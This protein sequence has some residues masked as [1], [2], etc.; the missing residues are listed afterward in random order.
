MTSTIRVVLNGNQTS[1][2]YTLI[3]VEPPWTP[4]FPCQPP[5]TAR[6]QMVA[7]LDRGE[8]MHGSLAEDFYV[9]LDQPQDPS[10]FIL[11]L[12]DNGSQ[13]DDDRPRLAAVA[14]TPR[15]DY[16]SEF[17]DDRATDWDFFALSGHHV[18]DR[19]GVEGV[20]QL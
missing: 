1:L 10:N 3:D 5:H 8:N 17:E 16:L 6:D 2:V 14:Y 12:G 15:S 11:W 13:N 20:H 18:H 19:S 9:V 7:W 4:P